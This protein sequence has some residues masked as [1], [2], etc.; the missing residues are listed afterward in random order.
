[1][2]RILF[3]LAVLIAPLTAVAEGRLALVIGNDSYDQVPA[4]QKARADAVAVA[5]TL[6]AQGFEVT[7]LLDGSRRAMNREIAAFTGR[8][9]P[10]DTAFVF[11]AGHGVEIG[12]ENYLLPTDIVAP[13]TGAEGFVKS[14][15]IGLASLLDRIRATGA[16]TTLAIIDACRENPFAAG[17]GRSVGGT[18]GLGRIAAPEGTFVIYSAGA[19]QLALDR[20]SDDDTDANSV[21]TRLLLP[22]LKEPGLELRAMMSGLRRD[23][24]DLARTVGH[25]QFPAY[26]DEL[27]GQFHFTPAAMD[28][29]RDAA[30]ADARKSIGSDEAMRADFE[31]ARSINTVDAYDMFLERY[32]SRDNEFTVQIARRLRDGLEGDEG[33]RGLSLQPTGAPPEAATRAPSPAERREIIRKTQAQLNA[34][35]C[36]VGP[37]DGIAG[38]RTL[39][40]FVAFLAATDIPM[41]PDDLGSQLALDAVNTKSGTLCKVVAAKPKRTPVPPATSAAKPAQP[42][43][44]TYSMAG[45]WSWVADCPLVGRVTGTSSLQSTGGNGYSGSLSNSLGQSARLDGTLSGRTYSGVE[46]YGFITIRATL[47]LAGDGRSF[48]GRASQGCTVAGRKR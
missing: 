13:E 26:Y 35:G 8:L 19:G 4:L 23:V 17:T 34:L 48:S 21:F 33:Q 16:R 12:G 39:E 11:F 10:G 29:P 5:E 27:L 3:F 43:A 9:D 2:T 42:K 25:E 31:L 1:M 20:L 14:E 47:T 45:N 46:N 41:G 6:D 24:R 38:R 36:D 37:A 28:V 40:G 30:P 32:G 15:S 22:R 44:P 18:R 7:T